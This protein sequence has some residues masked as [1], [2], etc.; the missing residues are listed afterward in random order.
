MHGRSVADAILEDAMSELQNEFAEAEDGDRHRFYWKIHYLPERRPRGEWKVVKRTPT[1]MLT[2]NEAKLEHA[3][4]TT[5][6]F[7][8]RLKGRLLR[9]EGFIMT[10]GSSRRE[11]CNWIDLEW[12]QIQPCD[13]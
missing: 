9:I 12:R 4:I 5:E 13:P 6:W 3:S 8:K 10:G 1:K 2:R 11:L 7:K